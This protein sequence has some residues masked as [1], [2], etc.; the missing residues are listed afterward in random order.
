MWCDRSRID[1]FIYLMI[2]LLNDVI[3]ALLLYNYSYISFQT[4]ASIMFY[5]LHIIYITPFVTI[6]KVKSA[7]KEISSS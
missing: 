4:F 7:L 6:Q 3:F 1:L 2:Y 5:Y